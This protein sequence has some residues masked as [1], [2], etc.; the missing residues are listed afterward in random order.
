MNFK[1]TLFQACKIGNFLIR[2]FS[3]LI[4]FRFW[5]TWRGQT[6]PDQSNHHI[7]V[8]LVSLRLTL[9]WLFGWLERRFRM[10]L[11]KNAKFIFR[12]EYLL[13]RILTLHEHRLLL[14]CLLILILSDLRG[15][16]QRRLWM[17]EIIGVTRAILKVRLIR[18]VQ[19]E[20]HSWRILGR[21][22]N[23]V[24][25]WFTICGGCFFTRNWRVIQFFA[26]SF[27][28]TRSWFYIALDAH[29]NLRISPLFIWNF[30]SN[31]LII[32]IRLFLRIFHLRSIICY[33]LVIYLAALTWGVKIWLFNC[34]RFR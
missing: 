4:W 27:K 31:L 14:I 29:A 25:T 34:W 3:I 10:L 17:V 20:S 21:G 2:Q 19:K 15:R 26:G 13:L 8:S 32:S 18:F 6:L 1:R 22:R 33:T 5:I 23:Y 11:S 7:F 24:S 30:E 16:I 12:G 28:L 9:S